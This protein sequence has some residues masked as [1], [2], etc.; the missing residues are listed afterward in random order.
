MICGFREI[1][2]AA[3]SPLLYVK[4][5]HLQG[6]QGE[7]KGVQRVQQ[8]QSILNQLELRGD[9]ER[10]IIAGDFNASREDPS[11]R[12]LLEEHAYRGCCDQPYSFKW[13]TSGEEAAFMRI[14]FI[15]ISRA[16][17]CL[18]ASD[19]TKPELQTEGLPNSWNP[20][21]HLPLKATIE[22]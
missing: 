7:A 21:D 20:S 11:L 16:L 13:G 6:G 22:I 9:A 18:E 3:D 15:L 12:M 10:V 14:D 1:G 19:S 17:R 2:A 4:D 8:V 5:V